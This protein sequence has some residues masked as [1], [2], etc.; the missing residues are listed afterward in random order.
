M[1]PSIKPPSSVP[2]EF[3]L[4]ESIR[5]TGNAPSSNLSAVY[6]RSIAVVIGIEDYESMS[7]REGV[8]RVANDMTEELTKRGFEVQ[9]FLDK[10]ATRKTIQQYLYVD[11][12]L[13]TTE[14]DRILLYLIGRGEKDS[15][16]NAIFLPY[17]AKKAEEGLNL[18]ILQ[19]IF[20]ESKAKHTLIINDSI[21]SGIARP[22]GVY[23]EDRDWNACTREQ[24]N[25]YFASSQDNNPQVLGTA[26]MQAF[27][28]A[29]DLNTDG[30]IAEDELLSFLQQTNPITTWQ[31]TAGGC[32][33]FVNTEIPR[34]RDTRFKLYKTKR[35]A[36]GNFL[37]GTAGQKISVLRRNDELQHEVNIT[38]DIYVGETEITYE[39][40]DTMKKT[41]PK[42]VDKNEPVRNISW[43][44]AIQF[45]NELSALEG[46]KPCYEIKGQD[47]MWPEKFECEG[48]RLPTEAEWEYLARAGS[49]EDF[50]TPKGSASLPVNLEKQDLCSDLKLTDETLVANLAW[51]CGNSDKK[52]HTVRGKEANPNG[53]YDT[54]GNVWEWTWD[55][56]APYPDGMLS[57]PVGPFVT[58]H[59]CSKDS[60]GRTV[61]GGSFRNDIATIRPAFRYCM[62]PKAA[63]DAIGFRLVR[64]AKD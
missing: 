28:G 17:D 44:D 22:A 42:N 19:S 54:I 31:A 15:A 48:W 23:V 56:Y 25:S 39:L 33:S 58:K 11:L 55:W 45:A 49:S 47:V 61:R 27:T 40:Y 29:G 16:D 36:A 4:P 35:V 18:S 26:L 63:T 10:A 60:P 38:R 6:G 37:M 5:F 64:T 52:I 24:K 50:T 21:N 57:D 13:L 8:L 12:P 32:L 2:Q 20:E 9:S 41:I 53:L 14:N 30:I 46:V 43:F 7:D 51:F 59:L 34:V 62:E 3:V 1:S